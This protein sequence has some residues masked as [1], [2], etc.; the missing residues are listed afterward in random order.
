MNARSADVT[1]SAAMIRSLSFS[2]FSSS[3]TTNMP[4][5]AIAAS[6]SPI[7]LRGRGKSDPR[8]LLPVTP[9]RTGAPVAPKV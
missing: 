2:R 4:P 9:S 1:C 7:V 5:S 8:S 3:T 6:A